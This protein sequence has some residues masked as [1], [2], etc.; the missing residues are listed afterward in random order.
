M[1]ATYVTAL[2]ERARACV[3]IAG[4]SRWGAGGPTDAPG[5]SSCG[6][7]WW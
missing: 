3:D 5:N 4:D 2:D 1:I 7:R 6:R